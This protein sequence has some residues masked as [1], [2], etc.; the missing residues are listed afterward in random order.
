MP[1]D[2]LPPVLHVQPPTQADTPRPDSPSGGPTREVRFAVVMYGGVSLC[3]YINGIAQELLHLV[4]ATADDP[5]GGPRKLTEVEEVYRTLGRLLNEE[6]VPGADVKPDAP[7]RTRFSVDILSGT[8]AG[9]INAVFLAKALALDETM[10][11]LKQLWMTEGDI[12]KLINDGASTR[13]TGLPRPRSPQSLLNGQRMYRKLVEAFE[14]MDDAVKDRPG[15]AWRPLVPE[16]DLFVT[17]TDIAGVPLP[18]RLSDGVVHERRHRGVFHFRFKHEE[19]RQAP[20]KDGEERTSAPS[21]FVRAYNPFLAFAARCTSA[22]PFAFEPMRLAD[23]DPVLDTLD[24]FRGGEA[25]KSGDLLWAP[26]LERFRTPPGTS[27]V[28][29]E[30]RAFGDGGYLDNKPFSYASESLLRRAGGIPVDRKLIYIEPAPE[31]PERDAARTHFDAL[32]NVMAATV[33]LPR[34]ETIREDL[35]RVMARNRLTERVRTITGQLEHYIHY[36]AGR[37]QEV[38]NPGNWGNRYLDEMVHA[39]GV[40]YGG[41]HRLRVSATTDW[42]ARVLGR[43]AG[44]NDAS[45]HVLALRH[46]V[47]AWREKMYAPYPPFPGQVAPRKSENLFLLKFDLAFR[48]R[49]LGYITS[50]IDALYRLDREAHVLVALADKDQ[51]ISDDPAEQ[52]EFREE[53]LIVKREL[54]A[55]LLEMR[56][57]ED[58]LQR[59]GAANELNAA[60]Q[61]LQIRP[62]DLDGLLEAVGPARDEYALE[63]LAAGERETK[64]QALADALEAAQAAARETASRAVKK[65]LETPAFHLSPMRQLARRVL[66]HFY[67]H[68]GDYDLVVFPILYSTDAGEED[69][70]DIIRISPEDATFV[71][72]ENADPRGRRKLA[73]TALFSFG[74]FLQDSWRANDILWGRLDGA[75]RI[76]CAMLPDPA[77]RMIRDTLLERATLA[78]LREE[79]LTSNSAQVSRLMAESLVSVAG[80]RTADSAVA[81]LAGRIGNEALPGRLEAVLGDCLSAE[82]LLEYFRDGY[83]VNRDLDPQSALGALARGSRVVGHMLEGITERHTQEGQRVR[84]LTRV[85][86]WF[87]GL[88]QVAVPRSLPA[89]VF[90]HWLG[91][92]YTL[93]VLLVLVGV[94]AGG[95]VLGWGVRILGVALAVHVV[96]LFFR[97]FVGRRGRVAAVLPGLLVLLLMGLLA[98]GVA[99]VA[100]VVGEA[101][102]APQ[103]PLVDLVARV[104]DR[105]GFGAWTGIHTVKAL[106]GALGAMIL[107]FTVPQL[108][109]RPWKKLLPGGY[110]APMLAA[111]FPASAEDLARLTRGILIPPEPKRG[112]TDP[113]ETPEERKARE[114]RD[115]ERARHRTIPNKVLGTLYVDYVFI[116]GY[117]LLFLLLADRVV[118]LAGRQPDGWIDW[119]LLAA[120]VA[121]GVTGTAAAIMDLVENARIHEA[122]T[123]FRGREEDWMARGIR[124]AAA[125]KWGL[126]F[127]TVLLLSPLFFAGAGVAHWVLGAAWVVVAVA[128]VWSVLRR[129][130]TLEWVFPALA[131][132][133]LAAAYLLGRV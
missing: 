67:R 16:L 87:W 40:A 47:R 36:A 7:V 109:L 114:A 106:C 9:G 15:N 104:R 60:L 128:G 44:I 24:A 72:D 119:A 63:L 132:G 121:A 19:P 127:V 53:L 22:F 101:V 91:L 110:G 68:Y 94:V 27:R 42:L 13:D 82:K 116:A 96:V 61:A 50:R 62:A 115:K 25:G 133:L 8:S 124:L 35:E 76:I 10:D 83:E 126:V 2:E 118:E 30:Q 64:L 131:V 130:R 122:F 100:G 78:I 81:R 65:E 21:D 112:R 3:I 33:G 79:L 39:H 28:E 92:F 59:R 55:G 49:R 73:G 6:R 74:G 66:W 14:G 29:P 11:Q 32:E 18:L 70:V 125:W 51:M 69:T 80:G 1:I 58:R 98:A 20:A 43:A 90:D 111:E 38:E 54:Y 17:T 86:T 52:A 103:G 117:W 108:F 48:I 97:D 93:A 123:A 107:A 89:L 75:E 88:V 26:F 41:Y 95:E 34:Y 113:P 102:A 23:I 84:W 37:R 129:P 77:D 4:R 85:A 99:W 56:D 45:D 105:V 120:G 46:L 71:F 12:A 5:P 31:H 57:A